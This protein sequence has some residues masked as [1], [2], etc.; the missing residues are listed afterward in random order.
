MTVPVP[1]IEREAEELREDGKL[2]GTDR[3]TFIARPAHHYD[4]GNAS[5]S[6][7]LV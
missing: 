1:M 3:Q 7:L 4:Q 6:S 5:G 2:R